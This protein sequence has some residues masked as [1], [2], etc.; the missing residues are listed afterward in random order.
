MENMRAKIEVAV[1]DQML[2]D[3]RTKKISDASSGAWNDAWGSEKAPEGALSSLQ[4]CGN[5][6]AR[7][8]LSATSAILFWLSPVAIA[9]A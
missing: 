7:C 6:F 5:Y 9:L 8:A 1:S 2:V 3:K 4:H